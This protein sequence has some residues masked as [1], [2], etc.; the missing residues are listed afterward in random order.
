MVGV[1]LFAFLLASCSGSSGGITPG[2]TDPALQNTEVQSSRMPWGIYD[3]T[4]DYDG[5]HLVQRSLDTHLSVKKFLKPPTCA[6]CFK[7]SNVDFDFDNKVVSVDV[8]IK[9]PTNLSGQ[10][11]RGILISND[12]TVYLRNADDW[13]PL[14]DDDDPPDLNSFR[15]FGKGLPS[16]VIGP[17]VS[18]TEHFELVYENVPFQFSSVIDAIYKPAPLSKEEPYA[19]NNQTIDGTLDVGGTVDRTVEVE[20]LDRFKDVGTVTITSEELGVDVT[21]E[22]KAGEQN[23]W[24]GQIS[25]TTGALIGDY[26]CLITANDQVAP[27]ALYDYLDVEVTEKIG[28]WNKMENF[29]LADSCSRDISTTKNIIT[30]NATVFFGGGSLCDFIKKTPPD[31]SNVANY[32]G[33]FN[34]DPK[35]P[36]VSP[37]PIT[38]LDSSIAGGVG[39]FTSSEETYTDAFYTG[40]M[41]SLLFTLFE[42][43]SGA[44]K[45]VDPGDGDSGRVPSSNSAFQG[46]DVS[47]DGQGN[48]Y[49]MWAD[50]DGVLPPEIYGLNPDYT[51]HDIFMGGVL[52][53]ELVGDQ[54]GKVSADPSVLK[55]IKVYT[56][57]VDTG[58][59]MVLENDGAVSR[60]EKINYTVDFGAQK[61]IFEPGGTISLGTVNAVDFDILTVN[62]AYLPNAHDNSIVILFDTGSGGFI[63]V[64]NMDPF[65]SVENIGDTVTPS[66]TGTPSHLDINNGT[67]QIVVSNEEDSA[68]VFTWIV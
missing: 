54:D 11:V 48:L 58:I 16:G 67:L 56:E 68:V 46:V 31:Y 45:Y 7:L 8:T 4:I 39:F 36:N 1:L 14:F 60:I 43:S 64:Y 34:I 27:Y 59:I 53:P 33:L 65:M 41:S 66:I 38:R 50:P 10:D 23:I 6:D 24:T 32:F 40:P 47:S 44:P 42:D 13:T 12:P 9:N 26:K 51:R 25:N 19:I 3:I 49:A 30:Q 2:L 35:V 55:A 15:L 62:P 18:A 22:K 20:V 21:L 37:Y 5:A 52:P 61:T 63:K 29:W 28:G 17:G 57:F